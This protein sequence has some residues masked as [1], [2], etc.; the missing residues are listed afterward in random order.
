MKNRITQLFKTKKSNILSVYFTAGYPALNDTVQAIEYLDEAGVDIIEVGFPFSD[1]LADGPVIQESSTAAIDNGMTLKLLF[2]QLKAIREKTNVPLAFMGYLN[3]V[4]QFGEE[5]FIE[6]CAKTGIDGVIIPDMPVDYY[7]ER[8]KERFVQSNVSNIFLVTPQTADEKARFIDENTSGFIYM[9][10]SNSITGSNKNIE[11]QASYFRR[12]NDLQLKN[13]KLTGF[14]IHNR[15]TFKVA[16]KYTN[17]A[18]IGS[19]F[20]KPISEKGLSKETVS[21]FIKKIK[22]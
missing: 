13:P 8:L 7:C 11:N 6:A 21:E 5:R 14:G 16:C 22:P 10:S 18:I 19:A 17:G 3:P 15:E 1:P 2:E 12:I 9:V 4:L 20:I